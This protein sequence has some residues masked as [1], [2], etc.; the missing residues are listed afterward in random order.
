MKRL[1]TLLVVLFAGLILPAIPTAS[2][3]PHGEYRAN[4]TAEF[5]NNT[6][7]RG[8]PVLV[9][10]DPQVRYNWRTGSPHYLV[11]A[12]HFSARWTAVVNFPEAGWYRFRIQ[13][14]DGTRLYVDGVSVWDHWIQQTPVAFGID[15]ELNAGHHDLRFEYFEATG[16]AIASIYWYKLNPGG[17]GDRGSNAMT[18]LVD[19]PPLPAQVVPTGQAA[20]PVPLAQ[21]AYAGYAY[22]PLYFNYTYQVITVSTTTY[23][24][25]PT[26]APPSVYPVYTYPASSVVPVASAPPASNTW[27]G[28]YYNNMSLSG[29]PVWTR[30]DPSINFDW[31]IGSPNL[32][33]I[34]PD[35]FSVRWTRVMSF[36]TGGDYTFTAATDD[37]VRVY[38]NG[39]LVIDD[40]SHRQGQFLIYNAHIPAGNHTIVMEYFEDQGGARARLDITNTSGISI[41]ETTGSV[42]FWADRTVINLGENVTLCWDTDNIQAVY[43]K[44]AGAADFV[45]VV[46]TSC[47]T[48]TP[49]ATGTHTYAL[50]VLHRNGYEDVRTVDVTVNP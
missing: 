47:Q 11:N 50:K 43:Y 17:E 41:T 36:P 2:A 13:G 22:P 32:A 25:Y 19:H 5:Y 44:R 28:E 26:T 27:H 7:L 14:D 46:G 30:D 16:N 18:S 20:P 37:G 15:V 31:G 49:T 29:T 33:I 39:T 8:A 38:L 42:K 24:N 9:R 6:D 21:P 45:G 12:D 10:S 48:D 1:M 40:W 35:C 23:S 4:W 3:A 34:P